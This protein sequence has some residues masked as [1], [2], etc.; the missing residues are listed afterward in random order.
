MTELAVVASGF[1]ANLVTG[2][3]KPGT[4]HKLNLTQEEIDARKTLIRGFNLMLTVPGLFLSAWLLG[5]PLDVTS[6]GSAIETAG[7]VFI[8]F[9]FSQ[10]TYFLTKSE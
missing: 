4:E 3:F 1:V 8:T 2:M 7:T 6:L 9:L 10:G 5:E